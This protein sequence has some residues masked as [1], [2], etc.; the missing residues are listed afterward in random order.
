VG[1]PEADLAKF[2]RKETGLAKKKQSDPSLGTM[3]AE[4]PI[5]IQDK[6]LQPFVH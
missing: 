4:Y 1:S 2:D 5:E 3:V 6:I